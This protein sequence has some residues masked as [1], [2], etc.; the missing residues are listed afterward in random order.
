M[1]RH[2]SVSIHHQPPSWKTNG[3]SC[4]R[5]PIDHALH[6][7]AV[8][9][10][11]RSDPRRRIGGLVFV[12]EPPQPVGA[13]ATAASITRSLDSGIG[14]RR[15]HATRSSETYSTMSARV[16][17]PPVGHTV[18]LRE[19]HP[20]PLAVPDHLGRPV[21]LLGRGGRWA[22]LKRQASGIRFQRADVRPLLAVGAARDPDPAPVHP[23][24]VRAGIRMRRPSL[25]VEHPPAVVG[26]T[27]VG[28][29]A[30]S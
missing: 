3:P 15:T 9:I 19:I 1:P 12:P 27:T 4:G 22:V 6:A 2:S 20:P 13:R 18:D 21:G 17:V 14:P 10:G 28:S 5:P 29:V 23:R 25:R 30:P 26:T 24:H 7:P 11:G 8:Q 16:S